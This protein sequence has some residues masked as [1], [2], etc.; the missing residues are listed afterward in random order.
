MLYWKWSRNSVYICHHRCQLNVKFSLK[1]TMFLL[2]L[3]FLNVS[4]MLQWRL[5]TKMKCYILWHIINRA[6]AAVW[7]KIVHHSYS[8]F[9][10]YPTWRFPKESLK[11]RKSQESGFIL[12]QMWIEIEKDPSLSEEKCLS[13]YSELL[14]LMLSQLLEILKIKSGEPHRYKNLFKKSLLF[15][16]VCCSFRVRERA[17][18]F[19]NNIW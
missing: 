12:F 13:S 16:H 5:S 4:P 9:S 19:A 7:V 1:I 8:S 14:S 15:K 11:I 2:S 6:A 10:D 17:R 18:I 3:V